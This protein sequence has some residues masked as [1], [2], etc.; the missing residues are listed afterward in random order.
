MPATLEAQGAEAVAAPPRTSFVPLLAILLLAALL[1][2]L[3]AATPPLGCD[4]GGSWFYARQPSLSAINDVIRGSGDVHPPL[5]FLMLHYWMLLSQS[6]LWLRALSIAWGLVALLGTWWLGRRLFD[7]PTATVAAL[8]VA[9]SAYHF[10]AC[11]EVRMYTMAGACLVLAALGLE[12]MREDWQGVWL[13]SASAVLALYTHYLSGLIL[14]LLAL[15]SLDS[16]TNW[17]R[18]WVGQVAVVIGFAPWLPHFLAQSHSTSFGLRPPMPPG[19]LFELLF[20]I[21]GG[22]TI[23]RPL[24]GW[25]GLFIDPIK[26]VALIF[27]AFMIWRL[28]LDVRW[29]LGLVITTIAAVVGI[30]ALTPLNIFEY[31]YFYLILPFICLLL[32]RAIVGAG[33]IGAVI[34][35]LWIA[36]NL[37][38]IGYYAFDPAVQPQDWRG[39]VAW[40][41]PRLAPGDVILVHPGMMSAPFAYYAQDLRVPGLSL[42]LANAPD[43]LVTMPPAHRIWLCETP[44]HPLVARGHLTRVL[45]AKGYQVQPE[46]FLRERYFPANT[47]EVLELV[48]PASPGGRR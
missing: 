7:T 46:G 42:V 17:R 15:W 22:S 45:E 31:K 21:T 32:A 47:V 30:T 3:P 34:L 28:R 35:A 24:A 19:S 14:M 33:R 20:E 6:Q 27:P 44:Y 40:L 25:G 36:L 8:L 16:R 37:T 12:R 18:W 11:E 39:A 26:L 1:R 29:M 48:N 5:Y 13:Y 38:S 41:A 43:D 4:D 9:T 2:L 10:A 23:P